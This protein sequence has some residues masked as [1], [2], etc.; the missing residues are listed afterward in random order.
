[1]D[2]TSQNTNNQPVIRIENLSKVFDTK[3]G[4]VTALSDINLEI[5]KGDIYGIIG[6]SGAG[7]STL[8][9]CMN[10][11]ER[12]TSGQ[13]IF[14]GKDLNTLSMKELRQARYQ[15]GMIFQHFNLLEQ[16]TAIKNIMFA[17]EIAGKSKDEAR[18][19]AEELLKIVDLEDRANSYP[20]QLSGGQK[21]RI[22]IARALANNP[23]VLLCD[24][25]TSAL[26]PKTTRSILNLLKDINKKFGITIV[27][28]THEMSVVSEIC[29]DVAIINESRIAEV[30]TVE[31]VFSDP[32]TEIAKRLIFPE[33]EVAAHIGKRCIRIF[34][35]GSSS[36]EPVFSKMILDCKTPV[37]I[38]YANMEDMNGTAVGQ[39]IVQLPEDEQSARKIVAYL[40]AKNLG[41]EELH[42]YV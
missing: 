3:D 37:N 7:K 30:G 1:M 11:L 22:A 40:R 39:M 24:E 35:D 32:K 23:K 41:V 28:I 20:A 2:K 38:L 5:N 12:P 13:V 25:A 36:F 26:D 4:T 27:I 17:M 19:R 9:R 18:K 6:L 42:H 33:G 31:Q 34:F 21:Q 15:I 16:K 8:V 14:E 10:L 29:S